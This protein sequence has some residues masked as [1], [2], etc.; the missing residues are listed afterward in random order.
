MVFTDGVT[1]VNMFHWEHREKSLSKIRNIKR[2][3]GIERIWIEKADDRFVALAFEQLEEA[4]I[5][6]SSRSGQ[7]REI[8]AA[9]SKV[10]CIE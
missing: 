4:L 6:W 3:E 7:R 1:T 9:M 10:F 8:W 2:E 5:F